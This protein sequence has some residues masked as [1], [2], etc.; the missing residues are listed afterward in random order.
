MSNTL[1]ILATLLP[2]CFLSAEPLAN[3]GDTEDQLDKWSGLDLDLA[4]LGAALD[5]QDDAPRFSGYLSMFHADN[6]DPDSTDIRQGFYINA[7]RLTADGGNSGYDW[8]ISIEAN[9]DVPT[10]ND[11]YLRLPLFGDVTTTFGLF[12]KPVLQS[13]LIE[14][15][16]TMFITRSWNGLLY[17]VRDWGVMVSQKKRHIELSCAVQDGADAGGDDALLTG[18]VDVDL[19]GDGRLENEGAYGA[20]RNQRLNASY[21]WSDDRASDRGRARAFDFSF[22]HRRWSVAG[23]VVR[24]DSGYDDA[25]GPFEGRSVGGTTPWSWT[26]GYMLCTHCTELALR[27]ED[28]SDP[29]GE[30]QALLGLNYYVDGHDFKWQVNYAKHEDDYS[31]TDWLVVGLMLS[32]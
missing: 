13:G 12:K 9:S 15:N 28:L 18:R 26:V 8:R 20:G 22:A 4:R 1:R 10:L 32:F 17:S 19:I 3:G 21:A 27:F 31:E 5:V 11:A 29:V 16:R 2:L 25:T 7:L 23:E 24:Y 14:A 6:D 30:T